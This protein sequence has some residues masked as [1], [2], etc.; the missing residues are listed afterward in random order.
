MNDVVR[1]TNSVASLRAI[2]CDGAPVNISLNV[3]VIRMVE[4]ELGRSLQWMICFLHMVELPFRH[5]F[6]ILDQGK[7]KW[8][9][10]QGPLGKALKRLNENLTPLVKFE[11]LET[12]VPDINS[13]IYTEQ[14]DA[15]R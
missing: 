12:N 6:E 7:L 3:G 13:N 9:N 10:P 1:D 15:L 2:G 4:H 14:Q 8:E 11:C 5:L